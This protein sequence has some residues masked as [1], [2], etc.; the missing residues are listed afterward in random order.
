ME[1]FAM[2]ISRK[3][4]SLVKVWE[5][6]EQDIFLLITVGAWKI[7]LISSKIKRSCLEICF[8][9]KRKYLYIIYS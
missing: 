4:L 8:P 2:Y 5:K 6:L 7:R 1:Y 3:I 9:Y